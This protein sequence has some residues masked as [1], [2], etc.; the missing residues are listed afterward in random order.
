MIMNVEIAARYTDTMSHYRLKSR[1]I[2]PEARATVSPHP[3]PILDYRRTVK[4]R[5]TDAE[6]SGDEDTA[7]ALRAEL[8]RIE[9]AIAAGEQWEVPF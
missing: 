2:K 1:E 9:R 4:A 6:W 5:L 3:I 8:A 7:A